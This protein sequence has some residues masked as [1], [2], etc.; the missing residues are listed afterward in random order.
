[1]NS[2]HTT[3]LTASQ[4]QQLTQL[5]TLCKQAEPLS[6]SAPQ[7]DGLEYFLLYEEEVLVSMLF[8][9]FPEEHSCECG[10]FTLPSR[11]KEGL[12]SFLLGEALDY[13]E[14]VEE[15]NGSQVDFCFLTDAQTPS[16]LGVLGAMG[17]EFWY[18][19]YQLQRLLTAG[20]KN[21]IPSLSIREEED[22]IYT[23]S[24][25]GQIIGTCIVLPSGRSAYFYGFEIKEPFRGRGYGMDFLL[26]MMSILS[27]DHDSITLQVS[28]LNTPALS[29]YKKTGFRTSETLSYYLY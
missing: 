16:A 23:A 6:L 24:L 15:A 9:F 14:A 2:I 20:D 25:D 26:G 3:Q 5:T 1:M 19:E 17:A 22:H 27:S 28:G 8:L 21:Y 10:A 18:S 4:K 29:L 12:F 7:E 11:R 13:L